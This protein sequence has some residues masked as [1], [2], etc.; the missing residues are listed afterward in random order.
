[1]FILNFNANKIRRRSCLV[2]LGILLLFMV[3]NVYM[4]LMKANMSVFE[5]R[6]RTMD[7]GQCRTVWVSVF[8]WGGGEK[9]G[10]MDFPPR[11]RA[12]VECFGDVADH[13]HNKI[14]RGKRVTAQKDSPRQLR[15]ALFA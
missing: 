2:F 9:G 10:G 15:S 11:G 14:L 8:T 13:P 12:T 6:V 1:M 4:N 5:A 3:V 7:C